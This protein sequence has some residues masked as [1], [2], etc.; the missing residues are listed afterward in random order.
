M[1]L[2]PSFRQRFSH[3]HQHL[4]PRPTSQQHRLSALAAMTAFSSPFALLSA[5]SKRQAKTKSMQPIDITAASLWAQAG[6]SSAPSCSLLTPPL[7][8]LVLDS[9]AAV[10]ATRS[11]RRRTF[12]LFAD[13]TA[14][15]DAPTAQSSTVVYAP[16]PVR[17]V[18]PA[19]AITSPESC[20]A[21]HVDAFAFP[22]SSRVVES[23][24][25]LLITK[26]AGASKD[27]RR[28][29]FLR[30]DLKLSTST[31]WSVASASDRSSFAGLSQSTP[32]SARRESAR[33]SLQTIF[34]TSLLVAPESDG[35]RAKLTAP[36][37]PLRSPLRPR[38]TRRASEESFHCRGLGFEGPPA[39]D[40]R[41]S[42]EEQ[43]AHIAPPMVRSISM[44]S[45]DAAP[46]RPSRPRCMSNI[47]IASYHE[48]VGPLGKFEDDQVLEKELAGLGLGEAQ[49]E[50]VPMRLSL[51]SEISLA[52]S[53]PYSLHS[54]AS[55]DSFTSLET[56]YHESWTEST[57]KESW[58]SSYPPTPTSVRAGYF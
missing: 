33:R 39:A 28:R 43:P 10:K 41:P 13:S 6:P 46:V 25:P 21:P 40:S 18:R 14:S 42:L 47:I 35:I 36:K 48:A 16:R 23:V 57:G 15:I 7:S 4:I 54:N 22:A 1:I 31:T 24:A 12:G 19:R 51:T 26:S 38:L 56:H 2:R 37:I 44:Y 27:R 9:A 34:G 53:M 32:R 58:K 5:K 8:P 3:P 49:S 17:P 50:F 30:H 20:L 52:D 11:P 29:S 55:T 45:T